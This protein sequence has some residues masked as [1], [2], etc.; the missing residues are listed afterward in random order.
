MLLIAHPIIQ[1]LATLLALFLFYQGV[2]RFRS[3]HLNQKAA[4]GW[5]GHVLLGKIALG[6]WLAGM[7]GGAST[8]YVYWRGFLITGTHGKVAL[9]MLPLIIFGLASG[10]YMN[11]KRSSRK[12]LPFVHGL[13]NFAVLILACFQVVTGWGVYKGFVLGV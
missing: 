6:L 10:L 4:F 5:K 7:L 8:V 12:V 9:A 13:N 3:L 2:Q 1:S 11:Y